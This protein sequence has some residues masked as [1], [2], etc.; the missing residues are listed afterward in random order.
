MTKFLLTLIAV[1][2]SFHAIAAE[3][4]RSIVL[5]GGCTGTLIAKRLVL[6]AAHCAD[7][8][9]SEVVFPGEGPIKGAPRMRIADVI[10]A[11][12]YKE[13]SFFQDT[14]HDLAL[15]LIDGEAPEG[16]VP[17]DIAKDGQ[18]FPQ[19]I[20]GGFG[21]QIGSNGYV[22][23]SIPAILKIDE[24]KM[25]GGYFQLNDR[26]T[27]HQPAR[28]TCPGDSGGP[29]FGIAADGTP[30]LYGAT[31]TVTDK[32]LPFAELFIIPFRVVTS[33]SFTL[34]WDFDPKHTCGNVYV[35]QVVPKMREFIEKASHALIERNQGDE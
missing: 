19:Y 9:L 1:S 26:Q 2:F 5:I 25:R 13:L 4:S 8:G 20:R 27:F 6:T 16:F 14:E 21:G 18:T 22:D 34:N 12:Q 35:V 30:Y 23:G 31:S 3:L 11:S 32:Y 17:V 10:V 7:S 29:T 28:K 33:L 15:A 24:V